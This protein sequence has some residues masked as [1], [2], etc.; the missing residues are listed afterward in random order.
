MGLIL[1]SSVAIAGERKDRS[2]VD[3]L[4][5]IRA[6]I[7]PEEIAFSTVSVIELEHGVWRAKNPQQA[8]RRRRFLDDLFA[9]VAIYPLTFDIARLAAR[10]DGESRQKGI[11]IPFQDLVIGVTALEFGYAVATANLR[12]FQMIPR[13]V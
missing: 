7:G 3:V 2:A 10:I 9:S 8:N 4:T 5:S 11:T 13:L 12:H 1:D 6:A